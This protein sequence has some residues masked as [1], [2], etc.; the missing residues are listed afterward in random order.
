MA[1]NYHS[2]QFY[3]IGPTGLLANPKSGALKGAPLVKVPTLSQKL[4][5]IEKDF[6]GQAL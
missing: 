1:V 2:Q 3:N 4:D 6:H 5:H